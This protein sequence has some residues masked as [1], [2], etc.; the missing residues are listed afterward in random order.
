MKKF[1][2]IAAVI[3][4]AAIT[5]APAQDNCNASARG[6]FTF[7]VEEA[8]GIVPPGR[9]DVDLGDIC[10]GCTKDFTEEE[11]CIVWTVT[12]GETCFFHAA[13]TYPDAINNIEVVSAWEV[14]DDGPNAPDWEALPATDHPGDN[15]PIIE[16]G[17]NIMFRA[18]VNSIT[19][20]CEAAA[21]DHSLTFRLAVNYICS[22]EQEIQ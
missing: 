2:A 14:N 16:A 7:S 10:P 19:P 18:C 17:N 11:G 20:S 4:F 3:L 8:I 15:F 12:G 13:Y 5:F 1:L 21:R 22:L 9:T 6:V